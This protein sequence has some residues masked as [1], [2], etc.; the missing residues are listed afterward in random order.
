[1]DVDEF[2]NSV[3]SLTAFAE[4]LW[5]EV[6]FYKRY[7]RETGSMSEESLEELAAAASRDTELGACAHRLFSIIVDMII[8]DMLDARG[9]D[10]VIERLL[11][12]V[13]PGR[14]N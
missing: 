11:K 12:T 6:E 9:T 10:R 13:Q 2:R 8:L 7:I 1:M 4:E 3:R 5:I 14:P